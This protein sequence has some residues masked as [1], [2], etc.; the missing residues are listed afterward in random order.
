MT[1]PSSSRLSASQL[2][3]LLNLVDVML[4]IPLPQREAWCLAL[5]GVDEIVRQRLLTVAAENADT[6]SAGDAMSKTTIN[7]TSNSVGSSA[8]M[9][10]LLD[11]RIELLWDGPK[12]EKNQGL[13]AGQQIDRYTLTQK[14]GTGGMGEVWQASFASAEARRTVALKLARFQVWDSRLEERLRARFARE[15]QILAQLQHPN[16]ASLYDAGVATIEIKTASVETPFFVMEYVEGDSIS[17]YVKNKQLNVQQIIALFLQIANAVSYAHAQF[18]LHRD[19]KP[20]NVMVTND[21]IAKLLD[22]GVAKLLEDEGHF[23]NLTREQSSPFTANYASPEQLSGQ[24]LDVSSDVYSLGVLLYEL[25][26][27]SRPYEISLH[28]HDW[29]KQIAQMTVASDA[30]ARSDQ[31]AKQAILRGELDGILQKALQFDRTQRYGSAAQLV[32]D[33]SAWQAGLPV[34]VVK[35]SASYIARKWVG[36]NRLAFAGIAGG[37]FSL[38]I[39]A[40]AAF[41]QAHNATN[42]ANRA[43]AVE[44]IL[45]RSL[46][47]NNVKGDDP[48]AAAGATTKEILDRASILIDADTKLSGPALADVLSLLATTHADLGLHEKALTLA[49]RAL[50]TGQLDRNQ[51]AQLLLTM[52]DAATHLNRTAARRDALQAFDQLKPS[53]NQNTLRALRLALNSYELRLSDW[54]AATQKAL[55]SI[56]LIGIQNDRFSLKSLHWL[57]LTYAQ[58]DDPTSWKLREVSYALRTESLGAKHPRTIEAQLAA[59]QQASQSAQP[60]RALDLLKGVQQK[61]VN[62]NDLGAPARGAWWAPAAARAVDSPALIAAAVAMARVQ[63][64]QSTRV[65]AM[66]NT[67]MA[68]TIAARLRT[69]TDR[70]LRLQARAGYAELSMRILNLDLASTQTEMAAKLAAD[71]AVA[72][73][74]GAIAFAYRGDWLMLTGDLSA[75]K[76]HFIKAR[77]MQVQLGVDREPKNLTEEYLRFLSLALAQRDLG[78]AEQI[79][80]Q[81]RAHLNTA[82]YSSKVLDE[83]RLDVLQAHQLWQKAQKDQALNLLNQV[84]NLNVLTAFQGSHINLQQSA[85]LAIWRLSHLS[86]DKLMACQALSAYGRAAETIRLA[87]SDLA[88]Q[89]SYALAD[90]SQ[91]HLVACGLSPQAWTIPAM[92]F[93]VSNQSPLTSGLMSYVLQ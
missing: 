78:Q 92:P 38:L 2:E 10:V 68:T 4:D 80:K 27:G 31:S 20:S 81:A 86:E 25:L 84:A 8:G 60:V 63:L 79:V 1:K 39:G 5:S 7:L 24:H 26:V 58:R 3:Q 9:Q 14:L 62:S 71:P 28:S 41:W 23:A 11:G 34:S 12:R 72:S 89:S 56:N 44:S 53:S 45:V 35:P 51:Q 64:T 29:R 40:S 77:D 82:T 32:A 18:V 21:G 48:L 73:E 46:D 70:S 83:Q 66:L 30:C 76:T 52:A 42:Q 90:I 16:I 55:E 17:R 85:R 88:L 36:R 43:L 6:T 54:P 49:Q 75:A 65:E 19:I 13:A 69:G 37:I 47:A 50:T 61:L 15:R 67:A 33:L 91:N 93:E 59:M 87:R 57:A 74:N 22:F